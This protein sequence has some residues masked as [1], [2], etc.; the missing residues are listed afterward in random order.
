MNAAGAS[1]VAEER[2][3]VVRIAKQWLNTPYMSNAMVLGA[4]VDC[5][6]ILVAVYREAGMI[7]PD[8]DP[9]PYP[10]Q[11]HQHRN[12]EQ[13]MNLTKMFAQEV[14]P[15]PEREPLP[16]DV[17]LFKIGRLFAHGGIITEWPKI[18]HARADARKVVEEDISRN[19]FGKHA[20][21]R[22]D[23]HFFTRWN[24]DNT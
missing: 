18:I 12:E 1:T 2:Q 19:A 22:C 14:P 7:P 10:A 4:G 8:F 13:Y 9:R 23:K 21:W 3:N 17:V 20:L 6:M 5:A 24:E 11:W 16:G 15:P